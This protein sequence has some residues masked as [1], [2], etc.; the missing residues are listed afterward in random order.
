METD[1]R[2]RPSVQDD[3]PTGIA[4]ACGFA[5]LVP[6]VESAAKYLGGT[7]SAPQIVLARFAVQ[8]V[9]IAL[10]LSA[11]PQLRQPLPRPMWPLI[12]RGVL[13]ALGSG[14]IYAGLSVMPLI[15]SSAIFFIQPLVL[16]CLAW[17]VLGEVV[18][19]SRLLAVV[20]G[21][22]GA[23]LIIGPNFELIGWQALF[24]ALAALCFSGSALL[25]RRWAE[26]A[27]A[28]VLQ[29]VGAVTALALAATVLAGAAYFD[30]ARLAPRMPTLYEAGILFGVGV[31]ATVTNLLLTQAFRITPVSIVG[32]FLYLEIVGAALVGYLLFQDVPEVWTLFGAFLVIGAGLYTW[33]RES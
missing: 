3:A 11:V 9:F 31:G 27:N 21:L 25:T 2:Q 18:T 30:I 1:P 23:L 13:L 7:T 19:R 15:E 14:L 29:L 26:L 20:V 33:Y 32:P 22:A 10:V 12:L 5:A 6:F 8:V 24:P 17:L 16:T 28:F 4:L